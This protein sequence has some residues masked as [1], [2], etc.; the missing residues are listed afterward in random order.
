MVHAP[1]QRSPKG[2]QVRPLPPAAPNHPKF[3]PYECRMLAQ[4]RPVSKV[5]S[6]SQTC[7]TG[8]QGHDLFFAISTCC[9]TWAPFPS[10]SARIALRRISRGMAE[11]YF[12]WRHGRPLPEICFRKFR[13]SL[14]GRVK[15]DHPGSVIRNTV[16]CGPVETSVRSPPWPRARSRA[17]ARPRPE[18]PGRAAET[19]G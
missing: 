14:K 17:M 10:L 2:V 15:K 11:A 4:V 16:P 19:K 12:L 9:R 18:P 13:P 8:V 3:P 5:R 6:R 7:L 1:L